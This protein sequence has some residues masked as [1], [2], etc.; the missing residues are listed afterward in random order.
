MQACQQHLLC[1]RISMFAVPMSP[2]TSAVSY[3]SMLSSCLQAIIH[4][5]PDY[6]KLA[7]RFDQLAQELLSQVRI[8]QSSMK[9]QPSYCHWRVTALCSQPLALVLRAVSA[10]LHMFCC[11]CPQTA[12]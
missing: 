9:P 4:F 7:P 12:Y 2:R 5:Q 6:S 10:A 1:C 3:A 11:S 8:Q